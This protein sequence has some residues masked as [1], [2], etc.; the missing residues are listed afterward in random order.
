MILKRIGTIYIYHLSFFAF[1]A[2]RNKGGSTAKILT[3]NLLVSILFQNASL[4]PT[5]ITSTCRS[6][7]KYSLWYK[8]QETINGICF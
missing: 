3:C 6:C 7:N 2:N 1:V 5:K 8:L 4:G